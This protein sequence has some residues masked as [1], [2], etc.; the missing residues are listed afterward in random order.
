[1]FTPTSEHPT[2]ICPKRNPDYRLRGRKRLSRC[3]DVFRNPTVCEATSEVGLSIPLCILR[4]GWASEL[5]S[6]ENLINTLLTSSGV[7]DYV[8]GDTSSWREQETAKWTWVWHIT[9]L[10]FVYKKNHSPGVSMMDGTSLTASLIDGCHQWQYLMSQNDIRCVSHIWK[11]LNTFLCVCILYLWPS[12][13]KWKVFVFAIKC[14]HCVFEL[15][16]TYQYISNYVKN[17]NRWR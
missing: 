15:S 1:M 10:A 4:A 16:N 11:Y 17:I 5:Y 7:F 3:P 12:F 14:F 9:C 6:G 13:L 2:E 8:I